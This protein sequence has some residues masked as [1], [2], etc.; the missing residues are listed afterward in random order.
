MHSNT[1]VHIMRNGFMFRLVAF[2]VGH[3]V[4]IRKFDDDDYADDDDDGQTSNNRTTHDRGVASANILSFW[5]VCSA[6]FPPWCLNSH[7]FNS[8]CLAKARVHLKWIYHVSLMLSFFYCFCRCFVHPFVRLRIA[9]SMPFCRCYGI[10]TRAFYYR[11]LAFT[12]TWNH[13]N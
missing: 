11:A 6:P 12:Q 2:F 9:S 7:Q 10:L 3:A 5:L 13:R 1:H 4:F 8:V